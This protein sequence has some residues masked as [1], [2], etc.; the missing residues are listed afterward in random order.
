MLVVGSSISWEGIVTAPNWG[1]LAWGDNF[2]INH[3]R[4]TDSLFVGGANIFGRWDTKFF[5]KL[6]FNFY[7]NNSL[8][9][10]VCNIKK[11]YLEIVRFDAS[12]IVS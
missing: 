7:E 1:T 12:D 4:N 11:I 6:I 3:A 2:L 10:Y 8:Q 9:V 5:L